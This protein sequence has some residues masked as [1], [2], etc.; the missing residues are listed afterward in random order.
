MSSD[1]FATTLSHTNGVHGFR[2]LHQV[3]NMLRK[4]GYANDPLRHATV[5]VCT[6][7]E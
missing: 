3:L 4:G 6:G 2:G 5:E 7:A 1:Q